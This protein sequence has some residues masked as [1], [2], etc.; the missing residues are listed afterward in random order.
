MLFWHFT[1]KF[2]SSCVGLFLLG[3]FV[4]FASCN[5]A[6]TDVVEEDK[7]YSLLDFNDT[8]QEFVQEPDYLF[9]LLDNFKNDTALRH[10]SL[11]YVIYNISQD[12][13]IASHNAHTS[14]V[15]ASILKLFTTATA[16]ELLGSGLRFRTRLCYQGHIRDSILHGD[17][18]I[19][20]GGDPAL[21]SGDYA[22]NNLVNNWAKHIRA[23]GIDSITGH[24]IADPRIFSIDAVPYTWSLGY[25][26]LPY[27]AA[28]HGINIYDNTSTF[29]LGNESR[30]GV[31]VPNKKIMQ[32]CVPLQSFI[33]EANQY[34]GKKG[35]LQ[36]IALHN[37]HYALIRG[38]FNADDKR[39]S[40]RTSIRDPGL[41]LAV[42][43]YDALNR[44]RKV[45][46][47]HALNIFFA[48]TLDIFEDS[49]HVLSTL[50]SPTVLSLINSVNEYSNNLFAEALI[51]HIG[52]RRYGL[53]HTEAGAKAIR[54]HWK[55]KGMDV[56]GMFIFDGSGLSRFNA[57][58][59]YS[60]V[61]LLK[62]MKQTP[63]FTDFYN[64]LAVS[65]QSGTLRNFCKNTIASERVY[66]KSG[67]MSR[68]KSYAGYVHTLN[69]DTLAFA[70]I[71]NNFTCS[72]AEMTRK[73]E[74]MMIG[75]VMYNHHDSERQFMARE[76]DFN[77]STL[78]HRTEKK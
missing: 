33:N 73:I 35:G 3:F 58:S 47:G 68:I 7:A 74:K 40:L 27:A 77:Y 16:L 72:L 15:P 25:L 13:L 75:M 1:R 78:I 29:S 71:T 44:D 31:V 39:V 76:K 2:F 65:G 49:L 8:I 67:T 70:L 21:G 43:L 48:D 57:L 46:G 26:S 42:Q 53:G 18:I 59:A 50:F 37:A 19:L 17:I 34:T 12:T 5:S 56:D 20:G 51:K 22:Q 63:F 30:R 38:H 32:P 11:A 61:E 6:Q 69:D 64:S 23:L 55:S 45:V 10:A 41:L 24:I 9:F 66:A 62:H 36:L 14:L 54:Q 52:L 60:F 28:A 4:V